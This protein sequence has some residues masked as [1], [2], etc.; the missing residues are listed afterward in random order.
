MMQ[1][2]FQIA[3]PDLM[4]KLFPESRFG[5]FCMPFHRASKVRSLVNPQLDSLRELL[6]KPVF[7]TNWEK[8]AVSTGLSSNILFITLVASLI[9]VSSQSAKTT[10]EAIWE[11]VTTGH[12]DGYIVV[13]MLCSVISIFT[14]LI[15]YQGV[16]LAPPP[17]KSGEK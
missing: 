16:A 5:A 1:N 17:P 12:Y 3:I 8:L 10:V 6:F 9:A 2:G 15:L 14:L 13:P 11:L 4:A 7:Y